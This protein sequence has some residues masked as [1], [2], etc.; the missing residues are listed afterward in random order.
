MPCQRCQIVKYV[1]IF[2]IG[3]RRQ[4]DC[5][6]GESLR[7]SSGPRASNFSINV[8]SK[9]GTYIINT[10][11]YA[12]GIGIA[13]AKI[14]QTG[15]VQSLLTRT[16][17][18]WLAMRRGTKGC[19]GG[20]LGDWASSSSA[21]YRETF[22]HSDQPFKG[23]SRFTVGGGSLQGHRDYSCKRPT[24]KPPSLKISFYEW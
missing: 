3:A 20:L 7:S 5:N 13:G 11:L 24:W 17:G 19:L 8:D 12:Q 10:E 9:N 16:Q 1:K 18:L 2:K 23:E 22:L 15:A 21:V 14:E 4:L 6:K